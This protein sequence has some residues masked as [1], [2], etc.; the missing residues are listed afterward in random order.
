MIFFEPQHAEEESVLDLPLNIEDADYA[1]TESEE[2]I[3]LPGDHYL[4]QMSKK[5]YHVV[6]EDQMLQRDSPPS[7]TTA[8]GEK[9]CCEK[10]RLYV[11]ANI[12]EIREISLE[13]QSF[14]CK[15]RLYCLWQINYESIDSEWKTYSDR[16]REHGHYCS[17]E[18]EEAEE[19]IKKVPHPTL[20]LFNTSNVTCLDEIPCIRLY[21]QKGGAVMMNIGYIATFSEHF[22]LENF[23]FDTQMLTIDLRLDNPNT[24]NMFDLSVHAVMFHKN[25]LTL[26]EWTVG[27][28]VVERHSMK[29]RNTKVNLMI[30]RKITY[31]MTNIVGMMIGLTLLCLGTFLVP[32]EDLA[33]RLGIILTLVLTAVAFKFV[34]ADSI[35]KLGY[36][37]YIDI[38]LLLNFGLLFMMTA[39]CVGTNLGLMS[40]QTAVIM[41][42]CA[43]VILN[44]TWGMF[45]FR[46][47]REGAKRS[48]V[49]LTAL[50]IKNPSRNFFS[51][52]YGEPAFM[53]PAP[54]K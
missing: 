51:C 54:Q 49:D 2:I 7:E 24:W 6:P 23:P 16:A 40:N 46:V 45:S 36:N 18:P 19:F 34:V 31:Y 53:L 47:H 44:C 39:A 43:I 33:D 21:P 20:Q 14:Q 3:G 35:P 52:T 27:S 12:S 26:P 38:F 25:A 1:K 30:T 8:C 48:K 50:H 28:P 15:L 32:E 4:N 41:S 37:T 22:E 10:I 5:G 11:T 29:F 42:V 17:L 13:L 9:V